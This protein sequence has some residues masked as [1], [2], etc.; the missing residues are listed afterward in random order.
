MLLKN[1]RF[2]VSRVSRKKVPKQASE[3][4]GCGLRI[5]EENPEIRNP[6]PEIRNRPIIFSQN[7][8]TGEPV[9]YD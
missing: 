3:I 9:G 7:P 1:Y 4:S 6:Q 5:E 2:S 8:T